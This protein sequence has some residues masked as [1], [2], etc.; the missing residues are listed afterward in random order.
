MSPALSILFSSDH[1]ANIDCLA[2]KHAEEDGV[3]STSASSSNGRSMVSRNEPPLST[4]HDSHIEETAGRPTIA[5]DSEEIMSPQPEASPVEIQDPLTDDTHASEV[6]NSTTDDSHAGEIVNTFHPKY[7]DFLDIG[8]SKIDDTTVWFAWRPAPFAKKPGP[9]FYNSRLESK[10]KGELRIAWHNHLQLD[11]FEGKPRE[12]G[13]NR[14]EYCR[15]VIR[16]NEARI[17]AE[18]ASRKRP[19]PMRKS[20]QGRATSRVKTATRKQRLGGESSMQA[21]APSTEESAPRERRRTEESSLSTAANSTQASMTRKRHRVEELL[22]QAP[23]T[24]SGETVARKRRRT[25]ERSLPNPANSSNENVSHETTEKTTQTSAESSKKPASRKR[26][27]AEEAPTESSTNSSD[28]APLPPAKRPRGWQDES[29]RPIPAAGLASHQGQPVATVEEEFSDEPELLSY[30]AVPQTPALV[31]P[32][33]LSYAQMAQ[34]YLRVSSSIRPDL[35]PASVSFQLCPTLDAFF[36]TMISECELPA[37]G[38]VS[39]VSAT[40][41]WNGKRHLIRRDRKDDWILFVNAVKKAWA[42]EGETFVDDGCE[43]EILVH[44]D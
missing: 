32:E 33:P 43:V 7:L 6:V 9:Q 28:E 8:T 40:Y 23:A 10:D 2:V 5:A 3:A 20:R 15:R 4:V 25:E 31:K 42:K 41:T 38:R 13:I 12:K 16:E 18:A 29:L 34:T 27:R 21:P 24:A 30:N 14:R 22:T 37:D 17:L 44:V 11:K 36:T 19:P 35:A 1:E 39:K 26:R